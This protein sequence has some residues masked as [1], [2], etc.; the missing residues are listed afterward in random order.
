MA[1]LAD[2]QAQEIPARSLIVPGDDRG[3]RHGRV[4]ASVRTRVDGNRKD[5]VDLYLFAATIPIFVLV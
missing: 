5:S 4:R 3:A 1:L 2:K